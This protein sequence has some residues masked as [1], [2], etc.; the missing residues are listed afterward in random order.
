MN[1]HYISEEELDDLVEII[2]NSDAEV[3][4]KQVQT[5]LEKLQAE[6]V[7]HLKRQLHS[8]RD[9]FAAK[10]AV[11]DH[12]G[13]PILQIKQA[14]M[15]NEP[16]PPIVVPDRLSFRSFAEVGYD[17]FFE[18]VLKAHGQTL[19]RMTKFAMNNLDLRKMSQTDW[20]K[21]E[22][23]DAGEYFDYEPEWWQ[24]GY[25]Q[26]G[27]IVGYVQPVLFQGNNQGDLAEATLYFIGVL[28]EARG[29]GYVNDLL[30]KS[31]A[32]LQAVGVW[33]IYSD[34]DRENFPMVRAFEKAGFEEDGLYYIWHG[35]L[36]KLINRL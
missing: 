14:F 25:N 3:R 16:R 6:G 12:L 22:F 5:W 17:V 19:D 8:L 31:I 15:W 32:I 20:L 29:H 30:A 7:T 26:A 24:I 21:S 11:I 27:E 18:T 28:P 35:E 10:K 1:E 34:T 4:A 36:S 13:I 33:R 23:D 9:D 2:A